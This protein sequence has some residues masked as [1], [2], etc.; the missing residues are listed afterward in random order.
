MTITLIARP[1]STSTWLLDSL[2]S[3]ILAGTLEEN[4]PVRQE[5]LAATYGVSRMP[6]REA[7][8]SLEA[9]GLVI[10]RPNKG[11]VVAPLDPEDAVEI[12]DVRAALEAL[13]LRRSVPLLDERQRGDA[14]AALA[15]LETAAPDVVLSA[16]RAFHLSLCA[17]SGGRL[18][19]LI[20]QQLDAAER[21][22]R[23]EATLLRVMDEDRYEHSALLEMALARDARAAARLIE[24]HVAGAGAE[25]A[26]A[27]RER[28]FSK[29]SHRKEKS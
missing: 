10:H 5:E 7:L 27:L 8:R 21:Y 28:G 1:L 4:T 15:A 13:A 11:V 19:R 20:G 2:R 17:A 12:F 9:E 16:H 25:L 24:K 14:V 26:E 29:K 18:L 3:A 6:V 22:L 23:A